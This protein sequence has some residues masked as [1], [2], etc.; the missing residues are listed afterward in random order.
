MRGKGLMNKFDIVFLVGNN[1]YL[2]ARINHLIGY[3]LPKVI[4][5]DN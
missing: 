4:P 5:P 3:L 1:G 2:L